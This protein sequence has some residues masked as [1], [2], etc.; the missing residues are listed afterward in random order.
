MRFFVLLLHMMIENDLQSH[1]TAPKG[2]SQQKPT[3]SCEGKLCYK[4]CHSIFIFSM[5]TQCLSLEIALLYFI[6]HVTLLI[7]P[8]QIVNIKGKQGGH[9][10]TIRTQAHL[11]ELSFTIFGPL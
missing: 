1:K 10:G 8:W 5:L 4:K 11:M 7:V 6:W 9:H 2:T 3:S